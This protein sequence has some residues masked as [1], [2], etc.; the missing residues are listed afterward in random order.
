MTRGSVGKSATRSNT[1]RVLQ[2]YIQRIP[3][4]RTNCLCGWILNVTL[5]IYEHPKLSIFSVE[6]SKI[7]NKTPYDTSQ[8]T[9][10]NE[11]RS[12]RNFLIEYFLSKSETMTHLSQFQAIASGSKLVSISN[13]QLKFPQSITRSKK[14]NDF[15]INEIVIAIEL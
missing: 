10:R 7:W 2:Q 11:L 13:N 6:K 12:L 14:I 15:K 5:F 4:L 3:D 1:S 8:R 9:N